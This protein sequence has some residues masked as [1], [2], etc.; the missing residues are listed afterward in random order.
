MKITE[1]AK[2]LK[3]NGIL[4]KN[5]KIVVYPLPGTGLYIMR[6]ILSIP[7][8]KDITK[9]ERTKYMEDITTKIKE[10]LNIDNYEL[11]Y[12]YN[13]NWYAKNPETG[14]C[15]DTITYTILQA[16]YEKIAALLKLSGL[17]EIKK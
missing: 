10:L 11:E 4:S 8:K 7:D 2:Y 14:K 5:D 17:M 3:I 6:I 12:Y 13:N 15:Y 1:I 9:N 16:D